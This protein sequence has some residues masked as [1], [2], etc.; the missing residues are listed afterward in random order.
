MAI[1]LAAKSLTTD[2]V[3]AHLPEGHKAEVSRQTIFAITDRMLNGKAE[4]AEPPA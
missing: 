1:P 2:V 3:Q 4:G